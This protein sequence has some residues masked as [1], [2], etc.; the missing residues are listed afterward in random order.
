MY[1][2]F[3]TYVGTG[4]KLLIF[5]RE[6]CKKVNI[7]NDRYYITVCTQTEQQNINIENIA[8]KMWSGSLNRNKKLKRRFKQCYTALSKKNLI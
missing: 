1:M 7:D 4:Y 8:S 3:V 5:A 2:I 6:K